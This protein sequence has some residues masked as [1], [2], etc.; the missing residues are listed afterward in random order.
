MVSPR[1]A[2]RGGFQ[3]AQLVRL[4]RHRHEVS[5]HADRLSRRREVELDLGPGGEG[6]LLAPLLLAPAGPELR[7]SARGRCGAAGDEALA[8]RR[9]RRLPPRC[10]DLSLRARGH[11]ERQP[12]RDPCR[13]QAPAPGNGCVRQGPHLH[14]R[15]QSLAGGRA[16]FL[17]QRRRMPS[18]LSLP[19]D[20]AHLHGDRAG[21]PLSDRRHPASDAG[22]SVQLPVGD[23]PAQPRRADA[24]NGDRQ[25]TRLPVVDLRRRSARAHQSR[26]PPASCAA[27][28]QR[29]AQ[30]RT[31]ELAADVVSRHADHLLRRRDRHGRQHLS[32]R[33]QRRAHADA[34]VAG[35]QWR[36]LPRRSRPALRAG[37]HGSGLWL[38]GRERGSAVAQHLLAARA[39]PSG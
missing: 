26:H 33:P 19:A 4:E 35:P 7:Q 10:R 23:V 21:R 30:D 1:A 15:S 16:G 6:L 37:H 12:S 14:R 29:P 34:V 18:G 20:A 8:G 17:R 28:G 22:H 11:A 24:R 2:Q 31:D 32:R 9:R 5:G 38:R 39:G 13:H 3:R 27:D 25:R 36:L